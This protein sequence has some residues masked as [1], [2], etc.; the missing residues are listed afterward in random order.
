MLDTCHPDEY[1]LSPA[2]GA[3]SSARELVLPAT[4]HEAS[5]ARGT[6]AATR[7]SD[8]AASVYS[9]TLAT[10]LLVGYLYIQC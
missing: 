5:V 9:L 6:S 1:T 4:A 10:L 2:H 8:F 7:D 3:L